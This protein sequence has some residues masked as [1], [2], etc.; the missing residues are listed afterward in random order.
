MSVDQ[1]ALSSIGQFNT[2]ATPLQMAMVAAAVANGGELAPR[3]WWTG[4]HARRRHG[5]AGTDP[6]RTARR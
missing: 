2:T 5:R 4:D 3:I 1:L 6:R